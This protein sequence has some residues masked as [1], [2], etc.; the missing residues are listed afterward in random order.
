MALVFVYQI[1][2]DI[3]HVGATADKVVA[4]QSVEVDGGGGACVD[5]VILHLRHLGKLP[6]Q[7]LQGALGLF[8]GRPL[9]HV[10]H[11][12]EFRLVVEGKHLEHHPLH[13]RHDGGPRHQQQDPQPEFAS[14]P[15]GALTDQERGHQSVKE[16][17]PG[18]AVGDMPLAFEQ[19]ARQP[20]GKDKGHQQGDKHPH[21][22]IDGN[23]AHVRPHQ[24]ADKG[25]GQQGR[26][27]GQGGEYGGATHLVYRARN[28]ILEGSLAQTA[29]A[30]D[31]LH[32]HDGIIHQD[33]D[34]EDEGKQRHPV[35]GKARDPAGK[36]GQCQGDNDGYAHHQR[37]AP[38]HAHQH[39]Q[40][41]RGGGED[42]LADQ[43]VGF[44][45]GG[46]AVV[47]GHR[48][49]DASRDEPILEALDPGLHPLGHLHRVLPRLLADG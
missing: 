43:G 19:M 16:A 29:M 34:G 37:L 9:R 31:V 35:E 39:Q 38:T 48:H 22:G 25:H 7:R 27:D 10:E 44:G 45:L 11:Q 46:D 32:H 20:G 28:E 5:L 13:H 8:Q 36:Q 14:G 1:D 3:P 12:L 33:A 30:V 24:A 15:L 6:P 2:L 41:H 18:L 23:G 42:E 4:H 21:A 40:H 17:G 26:N 47:T 49:L